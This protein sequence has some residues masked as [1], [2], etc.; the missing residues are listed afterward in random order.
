[1]TQD[2]P[3]CETS[4]C[5]DQSC[6]NGG[7]CDPTDGSCGTCPCEGVICPEGQKCADGE[8]EYSQNEGGGGAGGGSSEGGGGNSGTGAS[9]AHGGNSGDGDGDNGLWGL[10]TGGGGCACDVSGRDD[11]PIGLGAVGLAMLVLTRRRRESRAGS[12][13]GGRR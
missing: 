4:Q 5:T 3:S 6:P 9:G 8:C 10:A 11:S 7:C 2:P 1:M 13:E 12:S